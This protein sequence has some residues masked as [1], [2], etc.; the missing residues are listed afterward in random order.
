MKNDLTFGFYLYHMVFINLA[1]HKG[2]T[3]LE[4]WWSGVLLV[5]VIAVM[6]VVCAW[7]S[8]RFVENPAAGLLKKKG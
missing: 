5:T 8:S 1:M 7:L 3:S 4:P 6:T 2:F